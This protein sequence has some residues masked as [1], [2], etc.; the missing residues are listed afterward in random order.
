M[1]KIFL[2]IAIILIMTIHIP[3]PSL[4]AQSE[5]TSEWIA[6]ISNDPDGNIIHRVNLSNGAV[7]QLAV[8]SGVT[9]GDSIWWSVDGESILTAAYEN[10]DIQRIYEI[11]PAGDVT[12]HASFGW[13][14]PTLSPD[15]SQLAVLNYANDGSTLLSVMDFDGENEETFTLA[16]L[17]N[18]FWST[19]GD[20][21]AFTDGQ[22]YR[23]RPDGTDL[24]AI[25]PDDMTA[26]DLA[27]SPLGEWIA[28][29]GVG[30]PNTNLQF[31]DIYAVRADGSELIQL[32][33]DIENPNHPTWSP[34]GDFITFAGGELG[35]SDIFTVSLDD[36]S[37]VQHTIS[38][39]DVSRPKWSPDGKKIAFL[40]DDLGTD[41]PECRKSVFMMNS[42]GSHLFQLTTELNVTNYAWSP[43]GE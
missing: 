11:S 42:D 25:T 2:P 9:E 14:D 33:D 17:G 22:L 19:D 36:Q 20:W 29:V 8:F 31:A 18:P 21:I 30:E 34:D 10:H 24:E 38:D 12:P 27:W 15:Q 43:L 23:V 35:K 4:L 16:V 39:L 41:C 13:F 28:F 40:S 3:Q 7:E 32:T 6:I 5:T 1:R 26:F 37:I